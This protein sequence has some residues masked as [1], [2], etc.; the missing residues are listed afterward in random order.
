MATENLSRSRPNSSKKKN[1]KFGGLFL[2]QS[3][4][5]TL[6]FGR[7]RLAG[8]AARSSP[9]AGL[10]RLAGGRHLRGEFSEFRVAPAPVA[11]L[12]DSLRIDWFS[13]LD[14]Q[15]EWA[16]DIC[17][18]GRGE[19]ILLVSLRECRLPPHSQ[20]PGS[21]PYLCPQVLIG[22]CSR[23]QPWPKVAIGPRTTTTQLFRAT[24]FP[25]FFCGCATK[26]GLPQKGF[27]FFQG[28]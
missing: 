20:D 3:A 1:V 21:F 7:K 19:R 25:V 9:A 13:S 11:L 22:S 18:F 16:K 26:N 2:G 6:R 27:P 14:R 17:G 4:V 12:F 8:S 10:Q 15:K 28:H 23:S 5:F 24:F